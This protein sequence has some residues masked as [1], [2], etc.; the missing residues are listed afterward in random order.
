MSLLEESESLHARVRA[1]AVAT[2]PTTCES[3][4]DLALDIAR[5]QRRGAPGF[6]ALINSR[7]GALDRLE[8]IVAVPADAFRLARVA[9]HTPEFDEVR[10]STSGTTGAPGIHSMRTTQ[11]YRELACRFGE[12]ALTL[13]WPGKRLVVALAP[14]PSTPSTA[15]SSSLGFMMR[16]F[17]EEFD[18]RALT[19][20]PEGASF[21]AHSADRWLASPA[22]VDVAGLRRAALVASQRQEPLLVLATAFALSMLLDALGDHKIPAPKKTVVMVTGGFKGKRRE[23]PAERLRAG[24]ARS[25]R[26]P[27]EQVIGEYGMT[28]LTSQLYEATLPGSPFRADPGVYLPPRWMRV[29]P[30]DPGTLRPVREG[31][32]GLARFI[33]LGNVDSAVSV[34]TQDLVRRKGPGIEL[35]GRR[36]GSVLRGCSLAMEELVSS[37][38]SRS[39]I[40]SESL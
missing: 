25:F 8:D 36:P 15:P 3:F 32:V 19:L 31:E 2:D 9:V 40:P 12:L 30:V 22:G 17:M 28:E 35:L 6:R 1:F 27:R 20:N 24:V 11:T 10:F 18:G 4:D 23:V 37:S 5:F 34:V 7:G 39:S 16:A 29:D 14:P 13:P 38:R 21:D 26:I 33:D